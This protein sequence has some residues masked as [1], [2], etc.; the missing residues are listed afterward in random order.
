MA[1]FGEF[2]RKEREKKELNQ[3]EFGQQIDIIM[4][5]ISKIENGR[6]KFPF[7]Q[8]EK[9]A[10]FINKDV[11]FLKT[12]YVADIIADEVYKYNC[13]DDVFAVAEKQY[14]YL[15]NKNT[16]QGSLDF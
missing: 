9:L 13:S 4:T 2:L 16:I 15:K 8:L 10:V 1:T 7:T 3:S 5:D 14:Q 6:K 11:E 12:L